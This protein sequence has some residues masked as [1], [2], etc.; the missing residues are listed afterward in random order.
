MSL[1][2]FV[3]PRAQEPT[4]TTV[5]RSPSPAWPKAAST[6][7]LLSSTVALIL[8]SQYEIPPLRRTLRVHSRV[9]QG[10]PPI[11][12]SQAPRTQRPS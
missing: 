2:E 9:L 1:R 12:R 6:S 7:L 10:L 8:K 4:R 5:S 11:D 3:T